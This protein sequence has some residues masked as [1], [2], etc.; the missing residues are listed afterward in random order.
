MS[1]NFPWSNIRNIVILWGYCLANLSSLYSVEIYQ[2]VHFIKLK[3]NSLSKDNSFHTHKNCDIMKL[4][5]KI[6]LIY[7]NFYSTTKFPWWNYLVSKKFSLGEY[8]KYIHFVKLLSISF[9]LFQIFP[10]SFQWKTISIF[11]F[12]GSWVIRVLK[13]D[14]F[15]THRNCDI[16]EFVRTV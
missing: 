10:L 2:H 1:G 14:C 6:L 3:K 4:E 15:H 16:I 9:P 8:Q 5:R 7:K 13:D 11:I 12:L